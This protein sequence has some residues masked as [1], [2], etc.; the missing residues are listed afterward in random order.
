MSYIKLYRL[1]LQLLFFTSH[2]IVHLSDLIVLE[3][4][5]TKRDEQTIANQIGKF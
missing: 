3:R 5:R 2:K 1:P 4:N